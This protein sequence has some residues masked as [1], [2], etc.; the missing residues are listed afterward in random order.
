MILIVIII[1]TDRLG[2]R[3]ARIE[4]PINLGG[5]ARRDVV[6]R[7]QVDT[8]RDIVVGDVLVFI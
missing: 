2:V 5:K 3:Y 4:I 6:E 1:K 7:H 8:M